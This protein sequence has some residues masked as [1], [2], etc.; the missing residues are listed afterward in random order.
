MARKKLGFTLIELLV[1]IAILAILASL[2]LP[3]LTR[4]RAIA[5]ATKCKG[6][7]KQFG[8][9]LTLYTQDNEGAYPMEYYREDPKGW[10]ERMAPYLNAERS[11]EWWGVPRGSGIFRCPSHKK[12]PAWMK[13]AM[14]AHPDF[15]PYHPSYG[16]NAYG[17]AMRHGP[18][19]RG[20]AGLVSWNRDGILDWVLPTRESHV[21]RPSEMLA[22]GDGYMAYL[23]PRKSVGSSDQMALVEA[24]HLRR[25][26][27]WDIDP[28]WYET[29]DKNVLNVE[30]VQRWRHRRLNMTFCDGHVEDG[31]IQ[32][33][34]FSEKDEDL[35][36]WNV[37]N[38][39]R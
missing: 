5:L 11:R 6:N 27:G 9:G 24:G 19:V 35:R 32:K 7:L 8:L 25:S 1:V 4:A 15:E 13:E 14:E 2:L 31:S 20:L 36:L 28:L 37:S 33:W 3:A 21:K 39:P 23:D 12:F 17:G 29:L 16:Y 34:Y 22:I 26:G 38:E 10:E 30:E 18:E